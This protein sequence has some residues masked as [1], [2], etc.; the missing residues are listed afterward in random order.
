MSF[1]LGFRGSCPCVPCCERR[2]VLA[3]ARGEHDVRPPDYALKRQIEN[4]LTD[5]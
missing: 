2:A 1:V 3:W 5:G 4:G